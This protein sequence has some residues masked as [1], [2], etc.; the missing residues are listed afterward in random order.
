[1]SENLEEKSKLTDIQL[2]EIKKYL[3]KNFAKKIAETYDG[4]TKRQVIEVFNQR[5][6][7][8]EWNR[9]VWNAIQKKLTDNKRQDL[10]ESASKRLSFCESL[11][12]I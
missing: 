3:P 9:I 8:V 4:I 10:V 7:N 12:D 5:S 2:F 11:L 1:M 6:K